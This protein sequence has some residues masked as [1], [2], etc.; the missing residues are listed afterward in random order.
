M[1]T[2]IVSF[3]VWEIENGFKV[4]VEKPRGGVWKRILR[5]Q[6]TEYVALTN[7]Q[8]LGVFEKLVR[9]YCSGIGK[10]EL[11]IGVSP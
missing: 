11:P 7:D 6:R 4:V 5:P 1:S 9:A 3:D 2:L 8:L 10:F